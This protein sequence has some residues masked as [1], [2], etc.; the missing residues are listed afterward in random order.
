MEQHKL[1]LCSPQRGVE[2]GLESPGATLEGRVGF[3][4][5]NFYGQ[6]LP[7]QACPCQRDE[8][9]EGIWQDWQGQGK[10]R[11]EGGDGDS[12]SGEP[13]R[14]LKASEGSPRCGFGTA[15]GPKAPG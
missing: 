14:E 2:R 15:G 7:F 8:V 5:G 1:Q 6:P 12:C 9:G 4:V 11:R 10:R 13:D 3:P